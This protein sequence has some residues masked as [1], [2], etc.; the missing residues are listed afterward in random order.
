MII[1]MQQSSPYRYDFFVNMDPAHSGLHGSAAT[2]ADST[3]GLHSRVL[4]EIGQEIC[5]GRMPAGLT[6]TTEALENKYQV[7]RSV[8]RESL[9][10]L[11]AMGMVTSKRRVGNRVLPMSEWNVYDLSV[12]RWR[13]AGHGRIAQ[14]RSLTQL[15]TAIEPEAA[16]LAATRGAII[17]A[18]DLMGLAGRLWAAGRSGD[19]ELFLALDIEFHS[20]VM[21]MSGNEMFTRL[22]NLVSEVLIGRTNYGLMPQF[23]HDEA[24]Q[25][26]VDV[27][28]AIQRG[29]PDAAGESMLRIM[30]RTIREMGQIWDQNQPASHD[31][32]PESSNSL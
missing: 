5:E 9:R 18:S 23:P 26:H 25:L 20:L 21:E 3:R 30:N 11:E 32:A 10:A 14:L 12:I 1:L 16:K 29:N 19:Q 7:S 15:R 31:P 8:I 13:L 22:D 4:D 6:F 17:Q 28:N 27:A 24:L 2:R